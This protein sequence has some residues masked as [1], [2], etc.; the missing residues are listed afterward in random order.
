MFYLFVTGESIGS[1]LG[2]Y[3]F[4]SYGGVWSF[5]FFAYS[6]AFTCLLT[7]VTNYFGITKELKNSD[8]NIVSTK[9]KIHETDIDDTKL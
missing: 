1:I 3:L 7:I 8:N 4:D 5:R 6:S 2:G 9:S